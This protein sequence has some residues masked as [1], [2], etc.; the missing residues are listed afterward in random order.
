MDF[1][2]GYTG[3]V[4]LAFHNVPSATE[5]TILIMC[6]YNQDNTKSLICIYFFHLFTLKFLPLSECNLENE[7]SCAMF[8]H[9][10][11]YWSNTSDFG[12]RALSYTLLSGV[13]NM[14]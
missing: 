5:Q 6:S 11:L 3:I 1:K 9:I 14:L 13:T 7:M 8:Y 4:E 2:P 10:L 12:M